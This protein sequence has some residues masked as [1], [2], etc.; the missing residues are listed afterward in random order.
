MGFPVIGETFQL[1]KASPSIDI[2]RY[3]QD[4]LKR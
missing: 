4:R 2:P 3:Y 1:F